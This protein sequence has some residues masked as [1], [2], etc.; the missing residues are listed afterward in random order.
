MTSQ[1]I[2][3]I[4]GLRILPPV[5]FG[6]LGSSDTPM[7]N[8]SVQPDP[9]DPLG[10]RH[11][12]G[13]ETFVVDPVNGGITKSHV[14]TRLQLRDDGKIRPVAPFLEVWAITAPDRMEPLTLTMLTAAGLT[15]QSVSWTVQVKN[16]KVFRRTAD[17]KD[18][19]QALATPTPF[20]DHALHDLRG[21]AGN[22][23]P[24]S[25]IPLGSV[26]YIRPT[27]E[28]PQIRLRFT[29]GKG[30]VYGPA[31]VEDE[32]VPPANRVYALPKGKGWYGWTNR[33]ANGKQKTPETLGPT[34][35]AIEAPAPVWINQGDIVSRGYLDDTCDGIVTVS[36]TVGKV[37]HTATARIASAPHNFV[38]DAGFPRTL[39]DDLE[40]ALLGPVVDP[41][42]PHEVTMQRT[43]EIMR[44]AFETVRFMNVPVLNNNLVKGRPNLAD[45]MPVNDAID[46]RRPSEPAMATENTDTLAVTRLHQQVLTTMKA[47]IPSWFLR[48][49]RQPEEIGDLTPL[50]RRKMPALM[51]GAEGRYM[52]LTRRQISLFRKASESALFR[53]DGTKDVK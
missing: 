53:P 6:R 26:R 38:L 8:Y 37:T 19:I 12:Q 34:L 48:L 49:L 17:P 15:A 52:T 35:Y 40:Q 9:N 11:L 27:A 31:G 47:S 3:T 22:L 10:Y 13:E 20:T 42:E 29:P 24:N 14:P 25:V 2:P 30:G 32:S 36:L 50:G 28:F 41:T 4:L 39:G 1:P 33:D 21:T 44:R 16:S 51:S 46:A 18:D 5:A 23:T 7:D 43:E 45:N